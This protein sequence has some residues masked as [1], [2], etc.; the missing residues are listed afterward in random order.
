MQLFL[1]FM[2]IIAPS[3]VDVMFDSLQKLWTCTFTSHLCCYSCD[4]YLFCC[5]DML[6]LVFDENAVFLLKTLTETDIYR[7][8]S[9]SLWSQ[10]V[11]PLSAWIPSR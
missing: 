3:L 5:P 8:R 7:G 4:G 2:D 6:L 11:L 10:N 1:F 9:L